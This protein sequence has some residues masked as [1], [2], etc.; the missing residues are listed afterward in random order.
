M[1][2]KK[3]TDLLGSELADLQSPKV[4]VD[5][6]HVE[7]VDP[8]SPIQL[9]NEQEN[10]QS[11][12]LTEP[13]TVKE[14]ELQSLESPDKLEPKEPKTEEVAEHNSK[15]ADLQSLKV[16]NNQSLIQPESGDVEVPKYLQLERKEVRLRLDQLDA[17]T[18]LT[19]R[20][21]R[22]RKG[23]GERLT[24]NTLIRVAIDLLLEN[25]QQLQGITEDELMESLGL[26]PSDQR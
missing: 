23:K 17:L 2:R 24:E 11:L 4:T 13:K 19:R 25:T 1:A 10:L 15:A 14:T 26:P 7:E 21:N 20:L 3:I 16:T 22:A 18:T 5:Q 8:S 9:R 12:Q 6:G